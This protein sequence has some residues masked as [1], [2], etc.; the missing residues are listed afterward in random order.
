MAGPAEF[1]V[2]VGVSVPDAS[3]V[4]LLSTSEATG[5]DG[6]EAGEVGTCGSGAAATCGRGNPRAAW[7]S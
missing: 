6:S 5:S 2:P 4:G 1:E 3:P 7:P